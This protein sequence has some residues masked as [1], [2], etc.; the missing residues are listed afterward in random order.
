MTSTFRD[1][2]ASK[3]WYRWY[4]LGVLTVVFTSS[5]VDR[6]IMAITLQP[7]KTELGASD[8]QMGFLVGLTF[9]IFYATLGMP[10][11]MLADRVSRRN[12]ITAAVTIWSGMTVV[13]GYATS[14]VQLALARIG[15]GVGEAG[16]TPPSHSLI[17][18]LFPVATRGTAMGIFALGV[19]F[20]L[21]I[22][23]LAGGVVTDAWGWR[24]AF[25][26][27]GLPGLLIALVLYFTTT[28]PVRGAT[29][30][31]RTTQADE[32]P[33]FLAVWRH[34]WTVRSIRH[35][36]I[37]SALA[38]FTGY[39][40]VLWMPTFLI[41]SYGLSPTQVGLV[42]A[43]MTG[44]VGGLGTFTAGRLADVLARRDERWRSWLVAAGKAG[45]VPFLAVFFLVD[46]LTVALV[47]YLVPAFF[48]GFYLAP[49]FAL[50]QN[51]VSLRMRAL[52]SSIVLFILNIIG[53]GFGP[54]LVGIMSDLF[55]PS[56][57]K[58]S[59]RM[60]LLVLTFMNL[61][62]AYH[63]FRAGRTLRD[64]QVALHGLEAV[65]SAA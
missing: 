18:D 45:Y 23:Y 31:A 35:L 32:A 57:G 65:R 17:S 22:A 59:L 29:D 44:V 10:I 11:A 34:M 40:F 30:P 19:N 14:F 5:H 42:L 49:T 37:G 36:T 52:A 62:C 3:P 56:Y 38:G 28:E 64:D 15:V 6:Q 46:D 39:G 24:S 54:Q 1:R 41:R 9:A 43:L 27:V 55:A 4:A 33:T 13:C 16:S 61:W 47:L 48:G 12:I 63:Y 26:V 21:L 20:G 7:I 2:L 8:T 60:A 53:L 58:E 50:I 25:I 51:L